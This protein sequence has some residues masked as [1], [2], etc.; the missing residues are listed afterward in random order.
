[1]PPTRSIT[2]RISLADKVLPNGISMMPYT[3]YVA[4]SIPCIVPRA[5]THN[6]VICE[7][8][9]RA[10]ESSDCESKSRALRKS[11]TAAVKRLD[12]DAITLQE[13]I[14]Q[15]ENEHMKCLDVLEEVSR[16]AV[17]ARARVK[18]L[19]EQKE[20]VERR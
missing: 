20:L 10:R 16:K 8:C 15:A 19:R 9:R 2:G 7:A 12:R 13:Q 5:V 6:K 4:R 11:L 3:P 17:E 1:M 14:R 18:Q